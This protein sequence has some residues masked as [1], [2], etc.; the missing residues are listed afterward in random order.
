MFTPERKSWRGAN[1]SR[2]SS[3]KHTRMS[4]KIEGGKER[5][6]EREGERVEASES[7]KKANLLL[8]LLCRPVRLGALFPL[9][10]NGTLFK[11]ER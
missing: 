10:S 8:V 11:Q 4:E 9:E 6:R 1:K 2:K 5:E 3:K 7:R